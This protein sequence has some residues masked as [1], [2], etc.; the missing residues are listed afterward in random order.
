MDDAEL[1]AAYRATAYW[2]DLPSGE[3]FVLRCGERS[4]PLDAVLGAAGVDTWAYITASNPGSTRLSAAANAERMAALEA[5]LRGRTLGFLAGEGRGDAG[6]WPAE[7]SR[8][9]L[10]IAEP[11]A[12]TIGRGFGQKAILAGTRGGLVRL[13]WL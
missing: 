6:D 7:P 8:L 3:R 1:E 13:V 2:V 5:E 11:D 9:V 4:A 10:G 12:V